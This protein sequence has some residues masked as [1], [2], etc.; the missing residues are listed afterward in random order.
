MRK[1][2]LRKRQSEERST[3]IFNQAD[4]DRQARIFDDDPIKQY[5]RRYGW[6][7]IVKAYQSH[8][9]ELGVI[10]PLKLLT[11]PGKN[12]SDIGLF[13][14]EGVVIVD[15][16]QKLNVAI[17]DKQNANSVQSR[18]ARLGSFLA[19]SNK[20][21]VM[22]LRR[23]N[24]FLNHFPFDVINLDFCNQLFDINN[25]DN[26]EILQRIF[27]NQRGQA[28]LLLLTSRSNPRLNIDQASTII[29]DNMSLESFRHAF[30][31]RY[32]DEDIDRC[33][34]DTVAFTQIIFP[35]IVAR[36]A[37]ESGYRMIE[38]FVA[39]Y[40]RRNGNYHMIC[41]SFE[42]Q[43]L[44]RYRE[45]LSFSPNNNRPRRHSF[46]QVIY[47]L[48]VQLRRQ[49]EDEYEDFVTRVLERDSYDVCNAISLDNS[50]KVRLEL[51][52]S[53]LARWWD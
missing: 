25:T 51:E 50:L 2:S 11:L 48:P 29:S 5:I 22:T 53:Q 30:I 6:L 40:E 21:L 43:P 20:D 32:G 47:E 41:H 36:Y 18:L 49:A 42:F 3:Q 12:A 31:R 15:E 10:R 38:K 44:D 52:A 24:L 1:A 39:H 19:V 16:N 46:D 17:C 28:F 35:K 13:Y 7:D 23:D 45:S 4:E 27:W 37:R 9:Q 14:K 26:L 33:T 8:M 34:R